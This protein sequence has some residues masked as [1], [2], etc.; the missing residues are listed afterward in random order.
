MPR[1]A[2]GNLFRSRGRLFV[3]VMV[4]K[5]R[6]YPLPVDIGDAAAEARKAF[7]AD[8]ARDL[9]HAPEIADKLLRRAAAAAA[10]ELAGIRRY[11]DAILAGKRAPVGTKGAD[12]T[13]GDLIEAWLSGELARR[14][15]DRIKV[16]DSRDADV[17]RFKNHVLPA[18]GPDGV[19]IR[20]VRIVNFELDHG[21]AILAGLPRELAHESRRHVARLVKR[22]LSIAVYPMRLIA[23]SPLPRGWVPSA[24]PRKARGWIYPDEDLRLLRCTPVPLGWRMFWGFLAREGPRAH[25]AWS[26]ELPDL[27]LVRGIVTLDVNKTD[28]PRAWALAPGVPSA[29]EGW[30]SLRGSDDSHV[31]LD[32]HGEPIAS[33]NPG[34]LADRF[35]RHLR[36]AGIDRPELYEKSATRLPIWAHDLRGTFVTIASANGKSEAWIM[37]RTGHGTSAMLN[38][39]RR[40]IRTAQELGLGELARLDEAI[41]E[42]REMRQRGAPGAAGGIGSGISSADTK[43]GGNPLEIRAAGA[44]TRM[45][46]SANFG[47]ATGGDQGDHGADRTPF[48][49]DGHAGPAPADDSLRIAAGSDRPPASP[50]EQLAL[51][52]A[53]SLGAALRVR[54]VGAAAVAHE[55]LGKLL[56]GQVG[57]AAPVVELGPRIRERAALAPPSAAAPPLQL[58]LPLSAP[59]LP[60]AAPAVAHAGPG[61]ARARRPP[62]PAEVEADQVE[63]L[64]AGAEPRGVR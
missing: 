39:Y 55:A 44:P 54:D 16:K 29:I 21:E 17:S 34:Y 15:P 25:E 40:A 28:D 9:R 56:A 3:R 48:A 24:G 57:E 20:D 49:P 7:L 27:D 12:T 5:T 59:P 53:A 14:Y 22:L 61:L 6:A 10:G 36:L 31:F 13:V 26:L 23:V 46:M 50:R 43:G 18:L 38:R 45:A 58:E 42:L 30:L 8:V 64:V 41:P 35:R 1:V 51:D 37:D 2:T 62:P 47:G 60:A 19:P 52:L 11:V 33:R 63:Q 32:E 4:D